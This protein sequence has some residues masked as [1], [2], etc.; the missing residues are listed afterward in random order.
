MNHEKGTEMR[1]LGTALGATVL[2]AVGL[3]GFAG[4]ASAQS[5]EELCQQ[6]DDLATQFEEG[7]PSGNNGGPF[8]DNYRTA[9]EQ[10]RSF[11]SDDGDDGGDGGNP[12]CT[13]VETVRSTTNGF[14]DEDPDEERNGEPL[15]GVVNDALDAIAS[16]AGCP[17]D[18]TTTSTAPG[19][20][21]TD[22]GGGGGATTTTEQVLG[23]TETRGDGALPSTGGPLFAGLGL[24]ALGLA[25]LA[26]KYLA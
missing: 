21:T 2:V 9:A 25:A 17:S 15:R 4:P 8:P 26:R 16:G 6:F 23:T 12:I 24:G 14:F 19:T 13:L 5:Q 22:P 7:D 18:D 11:G 20:V 3:I 10:C 1:K